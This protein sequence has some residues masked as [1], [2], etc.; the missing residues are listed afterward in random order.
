MRAKRKAR[1]KNRSESQDRRPGRRLPMRIKISTRPIPSRR[2]GD[3][4]RPSGRINAPG[5]D[6]QTSAVPPMLQ[7]V[8]GY[9]GGPLQAI[10][11]ERAAT[12]ISSA[13][14][15]IFAKHRSNHHFGAFV[16]QL[17]SFEPAKGERAPHGHQTFPP[18]ARRRTS[19]KAG[20][21]WVAGLRPDGR[22]KLRRDDGAPIQS[23]ENME[24]LGDR[25]CRYGRIGTPARPVWR[26]VCCAQR[27][28]TPGERGTED[29]H[30]CQPVY[31]PVGYAGNWCAT[32]I[33]GLVGPAQACSTEIEPAS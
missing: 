21:E 25:L 13:T 17:T 10:S 19:K 28:R 26:E 32:P 20:R 6:A 2:T 5:K 7:S 31:G 4:L 9:G 30:Q 12:G 18:P 8:E 23:V 15:D 3:L 29:R 14:C 24:T 22:C 16:L 1:V 33:R 27:F 11:R